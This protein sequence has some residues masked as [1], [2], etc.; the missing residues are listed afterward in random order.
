MFFRFCLLTALTTISVYLCIA[1]QSAP[2]TRVPAAA[3]CGEMYAPPF[4]SFSNI[5]TRKCAAAVERKYIPRYKGIGYEILDSE[6]KACFVP[7]Q[8]CRL[9]DEIIDTVMKSVKY[10]PGLTNRQAKIEQARQISKK[11]SDTLKERGF[12]LHI[13]TETLSDAL[14]E[15]NLPGEPEQH[16]FDCDIGS[17]IFLTVAENLHAPVSLVDI[18]LPS[19]S[20][21]NYIRWYIDGET[22]LDWDMNGQ[23]ECVTPL[24]PANY[25]GK[26]MSRNDSLGYALTLRALLWENQKLYESAISDYR[27]ASKLYPQAPVS[28][29]NFAWL[30]ATKEVSDRKK[31]QQ[32]ARLCFINLFCLNN[33]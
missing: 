14:I 15:R 27:A 5:G 20:G 17:F 12:A 25:E 29:N 32:E 1:Q 33:A 6:S 19:G 23:A 8:A 10:K 26:S 24:N 3:Y 11:I 9:L 13:P 28:Y 4:A 22:S 2:L 16:V 30:I 7:D 31:F 18:T 21:H